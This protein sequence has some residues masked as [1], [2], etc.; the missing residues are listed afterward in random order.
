MGAQFEKFTDKDGQYRFRY[1]GNAGTQIL[2]SEGYSS[3]SGRQNG[4]DSVKTNA[5][6][7]S[8]YDRLTTTD[9]RYYFNM[10]ATNDEIIATS[11]FYATTTARASAITDVKTYAP[12][13]PTVSV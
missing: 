4:I 7:A 9:G 10:K 3:S 1:F 5:P 12:T 2:R 11:S 8:S 13:A 6:K